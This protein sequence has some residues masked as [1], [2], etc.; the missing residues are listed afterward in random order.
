[1][2]LSGELIELSGTIAGGGKPR[3]GGMSSKLIEE[4]SDAQVQEAEDELRRNRDDKAQVIQDMNALN[5]MYSEIN[6]RKMSKQREMEK[7]NIEA[8][9]YDEFLKDADRKCDKLK[10]EA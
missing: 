8:R 5:T 10:A 3:S 7:A 9:T 4:F 1:M 6:H 2:T